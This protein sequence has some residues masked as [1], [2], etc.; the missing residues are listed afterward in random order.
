MKQMRCVRSEI[1]PLIREVCQKLTGHAHDNEVRLLLGTAAAE[2]GLIFR[3]QLEDG[4]ARGLWQMEVRT[5][6]DI[7]DRYLAYRA[8]RYSALAAIWLDI[9]KMPY[10]LFPVD[11]DL[12][13]HLEK[14]DDFA[15]AM[16]RI[17]Y[18]RDPDPIPTSQTGR[19]EYWKRVYNTP[20]GAGTVDHYL[21]MWKSCGCDELMRE[22]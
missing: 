15:C 19:A 5:A 9:E 13:R 7:F 11:E 3:K 17:H 12:S 18:L 6:T 8:V 10:F 21:E 2:S 4:P 14:Y 16:A 20:A 22:V 1:V